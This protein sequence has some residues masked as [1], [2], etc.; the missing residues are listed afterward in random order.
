ML[1]NLYTKYLNPNLQDYLIP[2]NDN[3]P[4]T[5]THRF[6]DGRVFYVF[7]KYN[8]TL[9]NWIMDIYLY[10]SQQYIPQATCVILQ[11]GLDLLSQY[12][13]LNL[14]EFYVFSKNPEIEY[15]PN[16]TTLNSQYY[17]IWR[18]N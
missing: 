5:F 18:H 17:Y 15:S 16:A 4:Q 13:Y 7:L 3:V 12:K 2:I 11:F 6:G 1:E 9:D 10:Q 14:G 8:R